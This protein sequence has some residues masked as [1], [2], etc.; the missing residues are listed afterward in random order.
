MVLEINFYLHR[1]LV[2]ALDTEVK[3]LL[4]LI[5]N[6]Y[7]KDYCFTYQELLNFYKECE[8]KISYTPKSEI[9][10]KEIQI[11]ESEDRC[12]ARVWSGGHY[13]KDG[14]NEIFGRR[15]QRTRFNNGDFCRPH[16]TDLVHG[17]FDE[18]PN[19]IIKGFF[20]KVNDKSY[21]EL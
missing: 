13:Q 9:I 6:K 11:P 15:C 21:D 17:R 1:A 14:K 16:S 10:R 8:I 18:P 5:T 4:K 19:D 12:C 7:G 3:K 2:E 20:V